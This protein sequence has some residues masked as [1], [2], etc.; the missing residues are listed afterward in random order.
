MAWDF[1]EVVTQAMKIT[2]TIDPDEV[3]CDEKRHSVCIP[4]RRRMA[5]TDWQSFPPVP[6]WPSMR[7]T[8]YFLVGYMDDGWLYRRER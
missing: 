5:S 3:I 8:E 1:L 7:Y 2:K 4:I 6:L